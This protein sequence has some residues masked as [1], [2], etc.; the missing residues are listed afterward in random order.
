MKHLMLL[1]VLTTLL[2]ACTSSNKEAYSS[3]ATADMVQEEEIIRE[4]TRSSALPEDNVYTELVKKK[5][6]KDGRMGIQVTDL[7]KTKQNVDT[8][9]ALYNGYYAN[10]SF[11]DS[12]YQNT[13]LLRIRI[14]SANYEKFIAEIEKGNG[15]VLYKEISARDVTDQFIDLE[16][17]L[18][19]KRSYLNRYR[20]LV[21]QAKTI[22]G[23]LEVEE[24]IR[25]LEEEIESA[26][27]RLRLMSD[28]VN[29]SA[30]ELTLNKEKEY[31]YTPDKRDRFLERVKE[32][33]FSGWQIL[34]DIILFVFTIWPLWIILGAIIFLIRRKRNKRIKQK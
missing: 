5:I 6:I 11:Q 19:N 18:A 12:H 30:L 34:V 26:E 3:V 32:A 29:Y 1:F 16:T 15:K 24:H 9:L 4:G 33:L 27:G 25:V 17:R 21:K 10:E 7:E 8:A 28:Q 14:P 31:T 2:F 23:V 13:F 22:K 20:E